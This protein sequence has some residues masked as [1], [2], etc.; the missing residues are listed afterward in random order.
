MSTEIIVAAVL[1]LLITVSTPSKVRA[2]ISL[3]SGGLIF[4]LLFFSLIS[5]RDL[6]V[7][8]PS[9]G[10]DE[11]YELP[12]NDFKKLTE[13]VAMPDVISVPNAEELSK[14]NKDILINKDLSPEQ[15]KA[16]EGAKGYAD[17]SQGRTGIIPRYVAPTVR[18]GKLVPGFYGIEFAP[19][20]LYKELQN[21]NNNLERANSNLEKANKN[22]ERKSKV[23]DAIRHI[24]NE[25][26]KPHM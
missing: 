22:L 13:T 20:P 15:L 7:Y 26:E 16:L 3:L 10:E 24:V 18:D 23:L 1:W 17:F 12:Y 21:A 9:F 19:L 11:G 25:D 8:I 5:P 4:V 14:L 2:F 6:V